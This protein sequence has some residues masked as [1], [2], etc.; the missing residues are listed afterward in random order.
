MCIQLSLG[1]SFE[2]GKILPLLMCREIVGNKNMNTIYKNIHNWTVF[3]KTLTA[4]SCESTNNYEFR[5]RATA[6]SCE[7]YFQ[8]Q[9]E[10]VHCK[11]KY[12]PLS[13]V[14][15]YFWKRALRF[16]IPFPVQHLIM[17][18]QHSLLPISTTGLQLQQTQRFRTSNVEICNINV[19]C[20]PRKC[21]IRA[22]K[23]FK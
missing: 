10:G 21:L 7:R 15:K 4:P 6:P 22:N 5:T 14:L 2:T 13:L 18:I 3:R 20:V 12:I 11:L 19:E 9:T 1:L 17:N 16:P 8:Y 23:L